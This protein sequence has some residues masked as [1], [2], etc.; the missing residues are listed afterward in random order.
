MTLMWYCIQYFFWHRFGITCS[1]CN[2][3]FLFWLY[4]AL[5]QSDYLWCLFSFIPQ[6]LCFSISS[7]TLRLQ[8]F[9]TR[10][11]WPYM[12]FWGHF[13]VKEPIWFSLLQYPWASAAVPV[14]SATDSEQFLTLIRNC[15]KLYPNFIQKLSKAPSVTSPSCQR[16]LKLSDWMFYYINPLSDL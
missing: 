8:G 15:C 10:Y 11:C 6:L 3:L 2:S 13:N 14:S 9:T 16:D 1:S 7:S 4:L 12:A 5:P